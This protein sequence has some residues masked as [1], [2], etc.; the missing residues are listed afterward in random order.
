MVMAGCSG[1]A[2]PPDS[3]VS[4]TPS[5]T[6]TDTASAT[7]APDAT[8]TPL[9]SIDA[10]NVTSST[11]NSGEPSVSGPFPFNVGQTQCKTLDKGTGSTVA[12][13]S[14]LELNYYGINAS[15]G[16][17][18]QSSWETGQTMIG[19]NG[20]FVTGFNNCLTG[21]T[22]G[23]RVLMVISSADGYD[24]QGGSSSAGINVGDTLVF[25]VD[26]ITVGF[27]APT[28][29]TVATGNQ[30]VSVSTDSSGT[31]TATVNPGQSAPS[32]LQT[33]VLIQGT[34]NPVQADDFTLLNFFTMDFSSGQYIENSFTD[35]NGPQYGA[36]ANLIP[37][38]RTAI[39]GQPSGSRLLIIVPPS[40]AYPQGNATPSI[41]P[42]STLV[43]VVDI[44]F[45]SPTNAEAQSQSGQ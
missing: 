18:F 1:G 12:D 10:I 19:Q 27:T 21:Q 25:V 5:D 29:D 34:G 35:G 2:T 3:S 26:I 39:Q 22:Q 6:P 28:G 40:L 23:S 30:W 11:Y 15:T 7:P 43:C 45:T 14:L 33:T 31:P 32:T 24:A 36:L 37:G 13:D 20:G 16:V 17:M 44:L 41:A 9:A 4:A 38:W 42:N 8:P